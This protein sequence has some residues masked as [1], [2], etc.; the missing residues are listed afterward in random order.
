MDQNLNYTKRQI[1]NNMSSIVPSTFCIS[2]PTNFFQKSL[3][4]TMRDKLTFPKEPHLM[5]TDILL[6]FVS[7]TETLRDLKF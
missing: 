6:L 5:F 7:F 2:S 1:L 4:P 3:T